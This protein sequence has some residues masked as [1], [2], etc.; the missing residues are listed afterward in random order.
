M[1]KNMEEILDIYDGNKIKTSKKYVRGTNNLKENEYVIVVEVLILNSKNDILL[2]QRAG[3]KKLNPL[4]WETT[5][6]SVKSGENSKEAAVRELDEELGIRMD[7][8]NLNYSKTIKDETEHIFKDMFW[9]KKDIKINDIKLADGEVIDAKWVTI[10]EFEKMNKL[11]QLANN[12]NFNL[13][14][15]SNILDF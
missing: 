8:E 6:G 1:V 4:K 10:E 12:M 9:I 13:D 7:T 11:N 3:N 14:N 2:S 5:Q 15:I